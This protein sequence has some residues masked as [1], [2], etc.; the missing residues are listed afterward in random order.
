[1]EEVSH[2]HFAEVLL[3][4]APRDKDKRKLMAGTSAESV[5]QQCWMERSLEIPTNV[6][7]RD[8]LIHSL[9]SGHEEVQGR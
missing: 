1:M 5:Q 4:R 2:L 6:F 7:R 3:P 9:C 8:D